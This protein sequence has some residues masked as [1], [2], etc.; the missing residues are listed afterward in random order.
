METPETEQLSG[1]KTM[2]PEAPST[3]LATS[4][5]GESSGDVQTGAPKLL[6]GENPG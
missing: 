2:S 6:Q 5:D 4:E 3:V 1:M